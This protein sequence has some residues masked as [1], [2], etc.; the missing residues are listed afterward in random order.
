M[1]TNV[2]AA[3]GRHDLT[4]DRPARSDPALVA[5]FD[6]E[7]FDA[8]QRRTRIRVAV[9]GEQSF[10]VV[11]ADGGAAI[12]DEDGQ[13]DAVLSADAATWRRI[14]ADMRAGMAAY[15]SGRLSVRRNMHAGVGFLAATS[16]DTRPGRLRF[17]SVPTRGVRLSIVE[18]GTGSPVL[19]LHG[20]GATKGSFL[21]TVAALSAQ[22][23]VIAVDLP[24]FGDSDKPIGAAY[25][26]RFFAGAAVD[27]LDALSI[28]RAH[29]IG[30]SLGGRVALEVGLRYPSRVGRL[31][32]LAPSLAWR[33]GRQLVSLV[34]LTRPEL[35]L[36]QPAPRPIVEAV[37]QRMLPDAEAGWA[38]AGVDEFLRAF[39]T[40]SG[41]AA[42]Y[43]AARHIVLEQ[44]EGERGFWARLATLSRE[45]LFVWGRHDRLVPIA[46]ERHVAE[47]LPQASHL[48]LECGHVPQIEKPRETHAALAA[49]FT[50]AG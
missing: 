32:L 13:P 40:P 35:G 16:G 14:A 1:P 42:F 6:P 15:R 5:R 2:R 39:L 19:A 43:A 7:V 36:I 44:P 29:L 49:L 34:R 4:Y 50:A 27:L 31:G 41:R 30:N 37:I 22:F 46:F 11:V 38:A 48:E 33:R 10:D 12:E 23:R 9:A 47:A 21:P 24:G 45:A 8:R 25:N 20:L 17:R 28:E 3:D 18:A 26:A